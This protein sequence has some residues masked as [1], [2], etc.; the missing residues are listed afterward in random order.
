MGD[1]FQLLE[2]FKVTKQWMDDWH[3]NFRLAENQKNMSSQ[4]KCENSVTLRYGLLDA[5]K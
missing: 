4:K 5:F 2:R 3:S 1:E